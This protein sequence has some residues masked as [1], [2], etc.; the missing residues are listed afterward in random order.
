MGGRLI[1][2]KGGDACGGQRRAAYHDWFRVANC[3]V[4]GISC[5]DHRACPEPKEID[6]PLEKVSGLFS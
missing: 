2:R 3:C 4:A 5:D 6:R 1:S